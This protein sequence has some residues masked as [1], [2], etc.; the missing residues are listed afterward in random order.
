MWGF[1]VRDHE[2][3]PIL[4]GAG[5]LDTTHDALMAEAMACKQASKAAKYFGISRVELD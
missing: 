1:V 5:R 4:A 2:G 3:Q